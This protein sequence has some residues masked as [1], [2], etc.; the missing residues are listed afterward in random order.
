MLLAVDVGNTHVVLGLFVKGELAASFRLQ[1]DVSRT[2]DEYAIDILT[3]LQAAGFKPEQISQIVIS[4]VVP[5]LTRVFS[6]LAVKY[7]S[8]QPLIVGP[9]VKTGMQIHCDDPRSVGADRIVNALAA[10]TL[11]GAPVVIVDF[12][13]A[14]TFDVV[15]PQGA[16]EGGLISPGL[17]ISSNALFEKAA[18][19]SSIELK[20]P[21]VLIGKNTADSMLSGIVFGYVGLVDGI[22]DRLRQELGSDLKIVATGGLA[23]MI[24]EESEYITEVIPDLT[25]TG[26]K[27]VGDMNT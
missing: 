17:I 22:L 11:Y 18:K 3:L 21:N 16:Y 8:L 25:L 19:L 9:G 12:G 7:C 10:K 27:L 2:V 24:A 4:C 13:T 15:G 1:S 23:S 5:A 20:T 14:T 26:L 6:K